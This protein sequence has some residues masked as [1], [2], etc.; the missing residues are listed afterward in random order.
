[1]VKKWLKAKSRNI[2]SAVSKVFTRSESPL[3]DEECETLLPDLLTGET[4]Y[5]DYTNVD[6]YR[7]VNPLYRDLERIGYGRETFLIMDDSSFCHP[8]G[9]AMCRVYRVK[10]D[11]HW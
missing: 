6:R 10:T 1:M 11:F 3:P 8:D 9:S 5:R 7:S 2:V 4:V